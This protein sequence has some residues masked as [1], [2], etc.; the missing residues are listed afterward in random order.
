MTNVRTSEG[1]SEIIN[2]CRI[3]IYEMS[4]TPKCIGTEITVTNDTL[5]LTN[6]AIRIISC[7]NSSRNALLLNLPRFT[8]ACISEKESY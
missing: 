1:T 3:C 5:K 7:I 8:L 4:S 2:V 6:Y